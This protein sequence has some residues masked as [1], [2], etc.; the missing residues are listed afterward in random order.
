[1]ATRA[2]IRA[3]Y[4]IVRLES[5]K[6]ADKELT[7]DEAIRYEQSLLEVLKPY[8]QE[9]GF[10]INGQSMYLIYSLN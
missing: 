5:P 2:E 9:M 6:I 10:V 3:K 7:E 8:M 1:M 4:G